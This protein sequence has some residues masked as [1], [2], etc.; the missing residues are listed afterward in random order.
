MGCVD[1]EQVFEELLK[2]HLRVQHA[3]YRMVDNLE[4]FS[5]IWTVGGVMCSVVENGDLLL[6]FRLSYLQTLLFIFIFMFIF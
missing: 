1:P 4:A 6:S 2:A 3:D 5:L